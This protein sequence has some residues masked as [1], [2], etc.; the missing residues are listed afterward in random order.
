MCFDNEKFST[1]ICSIGGRVPYEKL[2]SLVETAGYRFEELV[3]GFKVQTEPE[4]VLSGYADAERGDIAFDFY[5]YDEAVEF[6]NS[7]GMKKPFVELQ[8]DQLKGLLAPFRISAR[9]A[10]ELYQQDPSYKIGHTVHM[11]SAATE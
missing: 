2:R 7:R 6:L 4:E 8:G 1:V 3:A 10:L 5:R 9:E 11:I